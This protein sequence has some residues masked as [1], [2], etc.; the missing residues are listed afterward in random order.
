M[1]LSALLSATSCH[2]FF[3]QTALHI[4]TS[5]P[6]FIA[7][8]TTALY[9]AASFTASTIAPPRHRQCFTPLA[10]KLYICPQK[11]NLRDYENLAGVLG[12]EQA[13]Q[14]ERVK[15]SIWCDS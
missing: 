2:H 7:S 3:K 12:N 5:V 8:G 1:F 9:L 13:P 15:N 10:R 11:L 4:A 6:R 14:E